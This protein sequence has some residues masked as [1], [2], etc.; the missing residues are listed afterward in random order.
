[1][2]HSP[3][4]EFSSLVDPCPSLLSGGR[5]AMV[6]HGRRATKNIVSLRRQRVQNESV[7]RVFLLILLGLPSLLQGQQDVALNALASLSD[8]VKLATLKGERPA[9]TRVRKIVYWLES[10]RI[11][12]NHHRETFL[13]LRIQPAIHGFPTPHA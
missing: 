13:K 10:A 7:L 6:I 1:M 3:T 9:N 5:S 11:N 4:S 8:P 2:P 12:G